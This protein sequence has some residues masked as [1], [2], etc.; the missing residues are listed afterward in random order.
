MSLT[1]YIVPIDWVPDDTVV[2]AKPGLD[3][4]GWKIGISPNISK[5]MWLIEAVRDPVGTPLVDVLPVGYE[6]QVLLAD[7]S[8]YGFNR[9]ILPNVSIGT[10][11]NEFVAEVAATTQAVT[12]G[13]L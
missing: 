9:V 10:L 7:V 6:T 8:T 4:V 3:Y 11:E 2:N 12:D 5:A 1:S 13:Y